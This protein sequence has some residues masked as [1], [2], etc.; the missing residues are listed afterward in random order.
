VAFSLGAEGLSFLH[1]G[2][3]EAGIAYRYLHADKVYIENKY[4]DLGK[5]S[6]PDITV[7]SLDLTVTYQVTKRFSLSMDLPF[8]YGEVTVITNHFHMTAGGP[9]DLRLVGNT[10]LLDPLKYPDGNVALGLGLKAPTGDSDYKGAVDINGVSV[11]RPVDPGLQPGDG[12]WG[13]VLEMQ[14]FQKLFE[15]LYFYTSGF[16]LIN[17]RRLSSTEFTTDP[18]VRLSVPDQYQGR[19]GFSYAIWPSKGLA[20]S[21]GGRIDGIPVRDLIGGGD[22]GFRRP[23]YT[24]YIDPGL[25]W[26]FGKNFF[27]VNVPVG[28]DFNRE[29]SIRDLLTNTSGAGGLADFIIVASYSR[30]F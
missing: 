13:V 28:V 20:L 10:W 29:R 8:T 30:R 3:W 1:P 21:L 23:G 19:A 4:V 7:H 25:S 5:D 24:I 27:S 2:Q 18:T 15:N 26:S 11:R 22:P 12:G 6:N 9:G 17:P 14:A 16:Y